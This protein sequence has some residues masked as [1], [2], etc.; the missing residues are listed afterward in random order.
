MTFE[1]PDKIKLDKLR[2]RAVESIAR[3]WFTINLLYI[4]LVV[5][6][7]ALKIIKNRD[8]FIYDYAGSV[9]T[10]HFSLFWFLLNIIG[11]VILGFAL[12]SEIKFRIWQ[13]TGLLLVGFFLVTYSFIRGSVNELVYDGSDV[14]IGN[15]ISSE[16]VVKYGVLDLIKTWDERANP[17]DKRYSENSDLKDSVVKYISKYNLTGLTFDKWKNYLDTSRYNLQINN[18]PYQ[19]P[20][21]SVIIMGVW[22]KI[23]PFGLWSMEALMMTITFLSIFLIVLYSYKKSSG[24]FR[25]IVILS[26]ISSPVLFRFHLPSADQPGMLLFTI[27]VFTSLLFPSKKFWAA[28][29]YG[30]IFGLCFY[31]K[32]TFAFFIL[33]LFISLIFYL[34]QVS[35]KFLLGYI[36]GIL[37]PF[38]VFTSLGYYFWLT[39]ITGKVL[40]NNLNAIYDFNFFDIISK[41]FYFGPSFLL[42][43]LLLLLNQDKINKSSYPFYIPVL[44]SLIVT[45]IIAFYVWNRYLIPYMPVFLLFSLSLGNIIELR[46]KDL[47]ISLIGN[48]VFLHLNNFI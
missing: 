6:Y 44:L 31:I 33:F 4:I 25:S 9:N 28:F 1:F 34:R 14:G 24:N 10:I 19:H 17:F 22:L 3:H 29:I 12:V 38:I 8:S 46:K 13:Y 37:I 5:V 35:L 18:R 45:M 21:L 20:P 2:N 30:I 48:F 47:I 23:F 27:P 36:A 7:F 42:I 15:Y 39:V 40:I 11:F 41:L 32:F 43:F 26:L 16:E